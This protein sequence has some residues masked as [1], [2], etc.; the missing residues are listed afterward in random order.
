LLPPDLIGD[1][2]SWAFIDKLMKALAKRAEG[3]RRRD[4]TDE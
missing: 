4:R 2:H 3:D 1:A